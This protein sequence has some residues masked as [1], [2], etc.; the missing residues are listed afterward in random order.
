MISY[1]YKE[2]KIVENDTLTI[3]DYINIKI[4]DISIK[5]EYRIRKYIIAN[6]YDR[7][8]YKRLGYTIKMCKGLN[9][10]LDD[11]ETIKFKNK[12]EILN[13]LLNTIV[14][15]DGDT[16]EN[17]LDRILQL[18]I[19]KTQSDQKSNTEKVLDV[20]GTFLISGFEGD[21][22]LDEKRWRRVKKYE[23]PMHNINGIEKTTKTVLRTFRK[24]KKG[25]KYHNKD[26]KWYTIIEND[27][28]INDKYKSL[29][30]IINQENKF[31]YNGHEYYLIDDN[32]TINIKT[33]QAK[34]SYVLIMEQNDKIYFYNEK[35]DR[36]KKES[37]VKCSMI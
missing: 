32:Y 37:V 4:F 16:L 2:N 27:I 26:K 14:T 20:L 29:W 31:K 22:I 3:R 21:D 19:I 34:M 8:H 10:I 25:K 23:K 13:E 33:E 15:D 24:A 12:V 7:M 28:N 18:T 11:V 1:N 17:E 30:I 35:F 36:I 5:Y 9:Y 6:K